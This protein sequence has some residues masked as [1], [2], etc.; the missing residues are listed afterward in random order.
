MRRNRYHWTVVTLFISAML[1]THLAFP[2]KREVDSLRRLMKGATDSSRVRI[3]NELSWIY[4]NIQVDSAAA[5]ARTALTLAQKT[6]KRTFIA[7]SYNSLGNAFQAGAHYDSALHYLML[8]IQNQVSNG[9]STGIANVLNNIGIIYDE[10]G[11]YDQALK[12]YFR[13]LRLAQRSGEGNVEAFILTNI[14]IVFKKQKQYDRV[15]EYYQQALAIYQKLKHQ[16]GI[17]V[18]SGNIGSVLIQTNDYQRSLQFSEDARKGYEKLGYVRYIPY[19]LGNMGIAYD[20]LHQYGIA[21]KFYRDAFRQHLGFENKYEAAYTGKNLVLLYLK[22]RRP[23]EALQFAQQSITLARSIGAKEMLRDTYHA[24]AQ[25]LRDLGR[26]QEA[27]QYQSRYS[28]LN[29][30]LKEESKTKTIMELQV[31]YETEARELELSKQKE[32]IAN[33]QLELT[34]RKYQ[35]LALGSATVI[36]IISALLVVQYQRDKRRKLEQESEFQLK[37]AQVRLENELHQDRLRISRDLHD[38]IGSRLLFLYNAAENLPPAGDG[39]KKHQLSQ[40]ARNTLHELRRTV[41]FINKE[42]VLLEELES[43]LKEY[44]QLLQPLPDLQVTVTRDGEGNVSLTSPQA[45]AIFRVAQEAAGNALK[46]A[47]ASTLSIHLKSQASK[48]LLEVK[49]NG[50][51]FETTQSSDTLGGNGLRN[52][53]VHAENVKGTVD[54]WSIV[55]QGTTVR[56]SMNL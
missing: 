55:G 52:M 7:K 30:S 24:L 16:F 17:T 43:R 14:G 28:T 37:L 53:K 2:Q 3:L 29:D 54:V 33:N 45:E 39:E 22:L 11:D 5:Y 26:Y 40:F 27:Y 31:R 41:W 1:I 42:T 34:Q 13:G 38:N 8:A 15:L 20:S 9:D 44:V 50:K 46:H 48:I 18:T 51:G 49:D 23:A 56:F 6:G 19:T 12:S 21:E 10:Q 47:H 32:V 36:V 25:T 4:K 35:L